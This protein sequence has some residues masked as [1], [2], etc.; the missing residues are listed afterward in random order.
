MPRIPRAKSRTGIY[1]VTMRGV[2]KTDI[3]HDTED[4]ETFLNNLQHMKETS[5]VEIYAYCLMTNHIHLLLKEVNEDLGI[6]FRRLG[7]GFVGWYNRKYERVG[8]LFQSRYRSEVVE[9]DSYLLMVMRYVHQNPVKAGLA[10]NVLDY[11]WSSIH[12]YKNK[13]RICHTRV[14]LAYFGNPDSLAARRDFLLAQ[15]YEVSADFQPEERD[16]YSKR[17]G[18]LSAKEVRESFE[19][20]CS[21]KNWDERYCLNQDELLQWAELMRRYGASWKQIQDETG[22]NR[23]YLL[24]YL[25]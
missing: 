19:D 1:H 11:P 20:T 9:V 23:H 3:F 12:E 4:H 18:I 15:E 5:G 8:H 17:R 24:K 21:P 16:E 6:S 7:A 25:S 14:G 10:R 2:N 22:I 13:A